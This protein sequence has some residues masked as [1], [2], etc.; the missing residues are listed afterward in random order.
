[1]IVF[2]KFAGGNHDTPSMV[3]PSGP[4]T[5]R[6]CAR[7][8]CTGTRGHVNPKTGEEFLSRKKMPHPTRPDE[9]P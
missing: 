8:A 3:V 5:A 2:S 4:R 7:T 6:R 1:M 9:L